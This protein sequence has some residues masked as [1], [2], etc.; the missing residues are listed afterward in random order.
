MQADTSLTRRAG[1]TGLGLAISKQLVELMGGG[2]AVRSTPGEGSTFRFCDP[3]PRRGAGGGRRG[4]AAGGAEAGD[5]APP[6]R[7]LLAEDNATNQ[8]LINAYLARG[9]HMR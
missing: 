1:G 4:A 8:Y 6:M 7:I 5:A 9:G 3:G 2:I